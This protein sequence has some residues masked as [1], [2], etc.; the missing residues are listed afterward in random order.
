MLW[1]IGR[2]CCLVSTVSGKAQK[3]RPRQLYSWRPKK[4]AYKEVV[5]VSQPLF[6]AREFDAQQESFKRRGLLINCSFIA[7]AQ[8]LSIHL[9]TTSGSDSSSGDVNSSIIEYISLK[10][11][12]RTPK[13]PKKGPAQPEWPKQDRK[14]LRRCMNR[15]PYKPRTPS[16]KD[17]VA[18]L[19]RISTAHKPRYLKGFMPSR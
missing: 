17:K 18:V 5:T 10:V 8:T 14:I 6:K 9:L 3:Y 4:F 16:N 19:W 12:V 1:L 11:R 15:G 7:Q 2:T 13:W